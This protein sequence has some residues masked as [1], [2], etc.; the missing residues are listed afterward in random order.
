V[1]WVDWNRVIGVGLEHSLLAGRQLVGVL[2]GVGR[3]DGEEGAFTGEGIGM[4][5]ADLITG[6]GGGNAAGPSRDG[7][8][9]VAGLFTPERSQIVAEAV[10]IGGLGNDN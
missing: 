9:G 2:R 8:V 10:R 3:R 1:G 5:V 7:A 6:G 4:V